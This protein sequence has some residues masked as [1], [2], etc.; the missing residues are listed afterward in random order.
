[1]ICIDNT[2]LVLLFHP[3]AKAP[4]DPNTNQPIER[5]RDRL[6]FLIET[7]KEKREKIIIPTP[8]LSEFLVKAQDDAQEYLDRLRN[9]QNFDIRPFDEMAAVE[10]AAIYLKER[11]AESNS[12]KK[13]FDSVDTAAR[14]KFDR[15]IVSIAIAR[16]ASTIYSDDNG[17]ATFANRNGLAIV[18]TW[19]LPLPPSI[20]P[21]LQF[22]NNEEET[23]KVIS[24]EVRRSIR[25]DASVEAGDGHEAQK[26]IIT[27]DEGDTEG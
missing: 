5:L 6:D 25:N 3:D 20:Q 27:Q 24:I 1:M 13:R 22:K 4:D 9:T 17:L 19:E 23:D 15:Q 10:L 11:Q 18:R 7:W 14:I 8:A 26:A 16:G 21:V 2:L 12:G